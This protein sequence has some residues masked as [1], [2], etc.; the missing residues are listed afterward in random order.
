MAWRAGLSRRVTA[1]AA[2]ALIV[3]AAVLAIALSA[4]AGARAAGRELSQRLVPA[5][6]TAGALLKEYQGQQGSLRDYVTSGQISQLEQLRDAGRVIP[7]AQARLATLVRHY[8]H[9]P[10]VLASA[11]AAQRA[12]LS[13]IAGPQL[14]AMARGDLAR[15]QALQANI[16]L[17]RP[18]T[19]A[20]RDKVAVLQA[21]ITSQ[22]AAV[23]SRLLNSQ[24]VLISALVAMCVLVA[25]ITAGAVLV[26]H[27][28]LLRPLLALR[29]ATEDVAAGN[30][31]NPIP[32]QGPQEFA[33]LARSTEHMRTRLLSAL[34]ERERAE[35]GFRRLFEAAPDATL[36]IAMNQTVAIANAQAEALFGYQRGDLAGV[37]VK[38]LVPAAAITI[39]A[40]HRADYFADPE[41]RPMGADL[42]LPAVRSDGTEFP[43]EISFSGLSADGQPLI[44]LTIRDISER[45]AVQAERERLRAETE[46]QRT[47]RRMQQAQKLESLGQLVGGVAH[48][49]NNLI[50]IITGYTNLSGDQLSPLA[51]HDARLKPVLSDI[52]QIREAAENAARLTRQLL[53]FARYDRVNP[54][55]LSLNDI[56]EGA[57]QLLHRTLGEH[58]DLEITSRP[59]LWPVRADRGQLE[60]VLVNLAINARDAMPRGGKLIIDTGNL[61]ADGA[62]AQTRPG[63]R[64]GR[65]TRLRV[66]DTGT[67]MDQATIDRVFEPFFTTKPKGHGTGLGLS[68]VYGIITQAGGSVQ[69]YSEPGLGTTFTVLI[70]A[71]RQDA[72]LAARVPA[73]AVEDQRGN[74]ETILLV[75]DEEILRQLAHRILTGHGYRVHQASTGP[76][77]VQYAADPAHAVDLL[78]TD[79]VMPEMLGTDVAD[80]VRRHRPGL[81]IVYMSGYA[82]PILA[83]HG[84]AGPEMNLIEKPF[85]QV[86]LLTRVHEALHQAQHAAG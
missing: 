70:P 81:P 47:Q 66:S 54:E 39:E 56:V 86:T 45:L 74:G 53:T 36:A 13:R 21:M 51:Q 30:Y 27:R 72:A 67:G 57:G 52:S 64:S 71:T 2:C 83:S 84:A 75:E 11:E 8:P 63:L 26:V 16:P 82:Q 77:A 28:W 42:E 33:D 5:A 1:A 69:I 62:Y 17:T 80:R 59:D 38:S 22:Q 85:T 35:Q 79:V 25:A 40:A 78:L 19:V 23:T 15:A 65:Y 41:P 68:T 46:Q 18:F 7:A 73:P 24:G 44:I 31:D 12:W 29:R 43:A 10:A 34:A 32:A 6:A 14:A 37:Q 60:Q 49:F 48:D 61:E 58:I 76:A 55:V 9:M 20:V 50:N 4:A 3:T